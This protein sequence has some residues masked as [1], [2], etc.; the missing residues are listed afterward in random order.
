M[1]DAVKGEEQ[2]P[3]DMASGLLDAVN[4]AIDEL[5][6]PA[7]PEVEG[8]PAGEVEGEV[9]GEAEGEEVGDESGDEGE[10]LGSGEGEV[11]GE[12]AKAGEGKP[13]PLNDPIPEEVK[14]RT[15][16]RI[17]ALIERTKTLDT[18]LQQTKASYTQIM[19]AIS[20][21]NASPEQFGTLLDYLGAVNSEDEV[22][23]RNAL[24]LLDDEKAA[25]LERLGETPDDKDLLDDP[26]FSDLKDEVEIGDI[27]RE[28][29]LQIAKAELASAPKAARGQPPAKQQQ[30]P[31]PAQAQ[32]QQEAQ[33]ATTTLTQLGNI[34]KDSDPQY[35]AKVEALTRAGIRETLQK[36][37]P[38]KWVDTFRLAY[39]TVKVA[40]PRKASGQPLR[41]KTGATGGGVIKEPG[42]LEEAIALGIQRAGGR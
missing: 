20:A 29:A 11:D 42:S 37:P 15:R 16:E 39:Q 35:A 40:P 1:N 9:E 3:V 6:A 5:D 23:L 25:I 34:L 18:E 19:E 21:T 27:S 2:A 41:G 31:V 13:D 4:S 38:S 26:R 17:T 8:E 33:V 12:E 32:F 22:S 14:G 10:E 30:Q 7:D 36:L 28:R 24:A